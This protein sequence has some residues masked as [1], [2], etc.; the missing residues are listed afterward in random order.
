MFIVNPYFT[1]FN[2]NNWFFN[3]ETKKISYSDSTVT[4]NKI[5]LDIPFKNDENYNKKVINY[6]NKFINNLA[7]K[8]STPEN[9]VKVS[10]FANLNH[11]DTRP[12]ILVLKPLIYTNNWVKI[13]WEVFTPSNTESA[14][15]YMLKM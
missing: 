12:L 15:I 4:I 1:I 13:P 6:F 10:F 3:E 2:E 9:Q 8:I 5:Y 11:K 7:K 14:G